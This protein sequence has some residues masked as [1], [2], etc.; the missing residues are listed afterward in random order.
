MDATTFISQWIPPIALILVL[1]WAALTLSKE[2]KPE[3]AELK[4]LLAARFGKKKVVEKNVGDQLVE[5]KI[6]VNN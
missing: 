4:A 2:M 1:V 3:I 6:K 5:S